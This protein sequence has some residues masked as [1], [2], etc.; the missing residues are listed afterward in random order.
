MDLFIE[1]IVMKKKDAKDYMMLGLI[2]LAAMVVILAIPLIPVVKNFWLV[3]AAGAVYGAYVL[4][5]SRNIEFEYAV[6]NGDLDIDK[7]IAQRKRKRIFSANCKEFDIVA[8]VG[9]DKYTHDI[10]NV[11]NRLEA[12]SSMDSPNIYFVSLRYKGEPWVVFF[13]PDQRMLSAFRTFIPRK[14]FE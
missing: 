5:R 8:K 10:R 1:K 2:A 11:K 12:V 7:I 3:L 6:T 14:V 9:S 4:I 13:E